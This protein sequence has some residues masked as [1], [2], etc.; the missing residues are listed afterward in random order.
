MRTERLNSSEE[1]VAKD[2][3]RWIVSNIAYLEDK[4]AHNEPRVLD[5]VS[6]VVAAAL[7]TH[8]AALTRE[9]D[10]LR[11]AIEQTLSENL[12]LA[13][14]DDCTL[15][16]LKRALATRGENQDVEKILE[17][18]RTTMPGYDKRLKDWLS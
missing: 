18:R 13:D 2:V 12:H 4:A 11:E 3:A 16:H 14:G 8:T 15:I 6:A 17:R 7:H 1:E 9:R 10:S 5:E